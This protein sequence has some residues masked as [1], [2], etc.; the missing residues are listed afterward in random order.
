VGSEMC[1]RDSIS[2]SHESEEEIDSEDFQLFARNKRS[3]TKA[4]EVMGS[5]KK[6]KSILK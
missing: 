1:I 6:K 2:P 5:G 3:L 4:R